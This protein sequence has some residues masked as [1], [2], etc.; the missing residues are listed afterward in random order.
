[1]RKSKE[2]SKSAFGLQGIFLKFCFFSF[3]QIFLKFYIKKLLV[4]KQGG[5]PLIRIVIETKLVII[6]KHSN[7]K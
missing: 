5:K 3:G 1:M 6:T 4:D 7:T 2:K